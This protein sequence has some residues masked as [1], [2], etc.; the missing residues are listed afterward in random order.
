MSSLNALPLWTDNYK[1]KSR[2]VCSW[3]LR[4]IAISSLRMQ[5]MGQTSQQESWEN[6]DATQAAMCLDQSLIVRL[7][8][9]TSCWGTMDWFHGATMGSLETAKKAENVH[10]TYIVI[11]WI[12]G[13][14]PLS[15]CNSKQ[16]HY[17]RPSTGV[18]SPNHQP[19][20]QQERERINCEP[21]A[22]RWCFWW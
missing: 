15:H 21:F 2:W 13:S 8:R 3:P 18:F 17:G 11:L 7:N 14:V 19:S 20:H 16:E 12:L 6:A 1:L 5:S 4:L 9:K 10:L 22:P